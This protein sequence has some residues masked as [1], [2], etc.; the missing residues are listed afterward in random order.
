MYRIIGDMLASDPKLYESQLRQAKASGL[1]AAHKE[2]P[3]ERMRDFLRK[4]DYTIEIPPQAHLQREL[5]VFHTI[6]E[7]VSARNWSLLTA[8]HNTPDF[9]TCDRPVS[10]V[11]KQL[12]FPLDARH[13]LMGA[14]E[15][16]PP[17]VL[18]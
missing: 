9:I 6:L 4:D 15:Q 5:A 17:R 7:Q 18:L 8:A 16:R 13:A 1:V 3:F 10:L 2:V 12:L 14:R 11:Y